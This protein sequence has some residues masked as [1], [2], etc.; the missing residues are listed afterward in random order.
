MQELLT[1]QYLGVGLPDWASILSLGV[2]VIGFTVTLIKVAKSTTASEAAKTAAEQATQKINLLETVH[3]LS[4][5][6]SI[7]EA[8]KT[9]VRR[10]N[11]EPLPEKLSSI[12]KSLIGIRAKYTNLSEGDQS[13]IQ[14]AITQFR[15]LERK[16][17]I[18][19][20]QNSEIKIGAINHLFSV[21]ID[22]LY[23]VLSTIRSADQ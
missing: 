8:I 23:E 22:E 13:T 6:L 14:S 9:D 10:R 12:R 11:F 21:H 7:L 17:D 4:T 18:E 5:L 3:D 20:E 1:S 2:A 19:L 16:I 15:S